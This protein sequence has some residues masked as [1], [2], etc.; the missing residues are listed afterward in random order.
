MSPARSLLFASLSASCCALLASHARADGPT[1]AALVDEALPAP[2]D[3]PTSAPSDAPIDAPSDAS[4]TLANIVTPDPYARFSDGPRNVPRPRGAAMARA[5]QLG[6]GTR[7]AATKL[8]TRTPEPRWV[9]EVHGRRARTLLWPVSGARFGRGFG[10]TRRERRELRH[11]GIDVAGATGDEVHAVAD[12]IVAYA[13]NGLRGYG[14]CVLLV[15]ANGTVSLY[16][17]LS[18]ITVQ[19]GW[20]AVRGERIG[21]VGSTGIA[22]GPHLHFELRANGRTFDP[23]PLFAEIPG[24]SHGR[25]ALTSRAGGRHPARTTC[26]RAGS[27]G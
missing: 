3:A 26:P 21:L 14:N 9:A 20:R 25:V 8:L 27:C 16:A 23:E 11:E 24:R 10:F 6:L 18:R 7:E 5:R 1:P 4:P 12:G 19:P 15:H 2:S 22:R 13:D 17:H